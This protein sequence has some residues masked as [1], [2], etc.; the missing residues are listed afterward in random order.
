MND[1]WTDADDRA[2]AFYLAHAPVDGRSLPA[3][4]DPGYLNDKPIAEMS[5][6]EAVARASALASEWTTPSPEP[7][8]NLD[9]SALDVWDWGIP[10][11]PAPYVPTTMGVVVMAGMLGVLLPWAAVVGIVRWVL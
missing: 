6:R 9:V 5:F 7:R 1:L 2:V 8:T 10:V 4:I 11:P 3:R